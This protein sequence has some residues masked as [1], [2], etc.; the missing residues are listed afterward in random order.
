MRVLPSSPHEAAVGTHAV[1][2]AAHWNRTALRPR[3]SPGTHRAYCRSRKWTSADGG[4]TTGGAAAVTTT[5]DGTSTGSPNATA[6]STTR[7]SPAPTENT[8]P[9]YPRQEVALH[10]A[11]DRICALVV[12][13]QCRP[14][15]N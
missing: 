3:G 8:A 15:S 10:S 11:H 14:R 13:S 1:A 6:R 2:T 12:T 5:S 9:T 4:T 7:T